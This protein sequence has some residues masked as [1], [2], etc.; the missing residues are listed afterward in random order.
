MTDYRYIRVRWQHQ[1]PD[2]PVDVWSELDAE[3]FETRKL[4]ICRDCRIGYASPDEESGGTRLGEVAVPPIGDI[5]SDVQFEPEE[6]SKGAF[7]NMWNK[8]RSR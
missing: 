1:N 8:R 7:E 5:A 3:R 6:V 4:E 2:E